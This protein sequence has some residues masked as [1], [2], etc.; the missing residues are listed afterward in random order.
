MAAVFDDRHDAPGAW[1]HSKAAARSFVASLQL[2]AS[3][4][5]HQWFYLSKSEV[6][7]AVSPLILQTARS[8]E[9]LFGQA[10]ARFTADV[11]AVMAQVEPTMARIRNTGDLC[12]LSNVYLNAV[13]RMPE[14]VG[15]YFVADRVER[16]FTDVA[17]YPRN[18]VQTFLA[19]A[20]NHGSDPVIDDSASY[21]AL[22]LEQY[23]TGQLDL[24]DEE[25]A[26]LEAAVVGIIQK[27]DG[28]GEETAADHMWSPA[29]SLMPRTAW[30]GR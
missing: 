6:F 26:G 21:Y 19:K 25:L 1:M 20:R 9:Y 2:M 28:F 24:S 16:R 18:G 5:G 23:E 4:A 3:D 27:E 15:V 10:F 13:R 30:S 12:L 7:A 14:G 8:H 29:A 11:G 17:L 22:L